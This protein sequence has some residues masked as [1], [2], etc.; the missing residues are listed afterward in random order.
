MLRDLGFEIEDDVIEETYESQKEVLVNDT[1]LNESAIMTN[2][3]KNC[4]GI[5]RFAKAPNNIGAKPDEIATYVL[6][7]PKVNNSTYSNIDE[8][9]TTH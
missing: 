7:H 3:C 2:K 1:C 5:N 9:Y 6:Y 8:I 4:T